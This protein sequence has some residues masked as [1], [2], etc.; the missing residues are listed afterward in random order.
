MG[1][2]SFFDTLHKNNR[3]FDHYRR[4]LYD[5]AL[6]TFGY[7]GLPK[8]INV[9][10]LE[11]TLIDKGMAV[12][13]YDEVMDKWLCLPFVNNGFDVYGD[14]VPSYAFGYN[15]YKH[16]LNSGE[17]VIIYNKMS[18]CGEADTLDFFAERL[19]RKSRVIDV[20]VNAQKTPVLIRT[21][22]RNRHSLLQLYQQY[23]SD[24]PYIW[25]DQD[26]DLS[27]NIDVL[28]TDA[29]F[30]SDKINDLMAQDIKECLSYF[31]VT[32]AIDAKKER[33]VSGEADQNAGDSNASILSR[34]YMRETAIEQFNKLSGLNCEVFFKPRYLDQKE[35]MDNLEPVHYDNKADMQQ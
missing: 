27:K 25:G 8:S 17:C 30:V 29:P 19:Y 21:S 26:I 24:T 13:F 3:T 20:N 33:L 6:S 9:R 11:Q 16:E 22:Q 14:P 5:I 7:K 34:L 28:K 23:D 12:I 31:G 15:S 32:T 1:N 10:F 2:I 35:V 4:W 18:K